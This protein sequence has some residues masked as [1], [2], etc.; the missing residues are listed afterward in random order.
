MYAFPAS[1]D[2]SDWEMVTSQTYNADMQDGIIQFEQIKN[3]KVVANS[4]LEPKRPPK[5]RSIKPLEL[6][7]NVIKAL[8]EENPVQLIEPEI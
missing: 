4:R 1:V 7:V 8:I 6:E 2:T 3:I 5:R